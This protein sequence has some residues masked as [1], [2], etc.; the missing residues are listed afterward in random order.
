MAVYAGFP[1]A[2][3]GLVL[4]QE[5]FAETADN[6]KQST[7]SP[8]EI[9]KAYFT[10]FLGGDLEATLAM[11]SEDVTWTVQGAPNVPTVGT[12][13]GK[14]HVKNWMLNFPKQFKPLVF[15]LDHYFESDDEVIVTGRFKHLVLAT[16]RE[17]GS[18]LAIHFITSIAVFR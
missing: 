1:A 11:L 4:A 13:Q 9:V 17:V 18:E 15:E 12:L 6:P 8:T 5:I 7:P 16:K 10:A 14:Q 3:R 2:L